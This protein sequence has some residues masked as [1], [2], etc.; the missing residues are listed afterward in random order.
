MPAQLVGVSPPLGGAG[1]SGLRE[2]LSLPP[3]RF[4]IL[5]NS[6]AGRGGLNLRYAR[7][8]VAASTTT[9][10][11]EASKATEDGSGTLAE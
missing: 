6:A 8:L 5:Y 9:P 10:R 2:R 7:R 3:S 4:K 11:A 1:V